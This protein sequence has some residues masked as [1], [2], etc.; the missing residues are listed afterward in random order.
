MLSLRIVVLPCA[1][2]LEMPARS[3]RRSMSARI[4]PGATRRT[5]TLAFG[6][7]LLTSNFKSGRHHVGPGVLLHDRQQTGVQEPDLEEHEERDGR[8]NA[9]RERVEHG[10]REIEAE[11][12]LHHRLHGD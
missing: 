12:E 6:T 5:A 8:V 4:V 11:R 2:A 3:T 10:P 7:C 1:S 9:V